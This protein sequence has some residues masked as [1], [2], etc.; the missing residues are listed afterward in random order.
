MSFAEATR[1]LRAQAKQIC[2]DFVKPYLA[3]LRQL[4]AYV[5]QVN[6]YHVLHSSVCQMGRCQL[7][8]PYSSNTPTHMCEPPLVFFYA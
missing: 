7:L 8:I 4:F 5:V 3:A 1:A 6:P 2:P